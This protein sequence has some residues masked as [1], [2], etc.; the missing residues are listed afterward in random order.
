MDD[1]KNLNL[2]FSILEK[3]TDWGVQDL[4]VAAGGRNEP[5]VEAIH[6]VR[7]CFKVFSFFEERSAGF[8]ALGRMTRNGGRPVAV[9][10]TSGTAVGELLPAVME[11]FHSQLP[12]IVLSADRPS[13]HRG[14]GTP[15][16][17]DQ[18]GVFGNFVS[19]C[20][21]VT[22]LQDWQ[23]WK[24]TLHPIP[25]HINVCFEEPLIFPPACLTE[26]ALS[27]KNHLHFSEKNSSSW[28]PSKDF[29][30]LPHCQMPLF[31]PSWTD[32]SAY[33]RPLLI[34]SGLPTREEQ[35]R[36]KEWLLQAQV[37]AY[38]EA[39][40]GLREDPALQPYRIFCPEGFLARATQIGYPI[41]HVIRVGRVPTTRLWRDLEHS[42]LP[43]FSF[44]DLP[45]LGLARQNVFCFP[46]HTL[47]TRNIAFQSPP[48]LLWETEQQL[49]TQLASLLASEPLSEPSIVWQISQAIPEGSHIFLGTSLPIRS[50]DLASNPSRVSS[51]AAR[52]LNGIDGQV[53]YCLGSAHPKDTSHWGLLGDLGTL[54]DLS[55]AWAHPQLPPLSLNLVVINNYGGQIF[56]RLYPHR[57]PFYLGSH[58]LSF[59]SWATLWNFSYQCYPENTEL[60]IAPLGQPQ[61]IEARPNPQATERFWTQY[62]HMLQNLP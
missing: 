27:F 58:S 53:S 37:P 24:G 13:S 59:E 16:A 62:H 42:R 28:P 2:V 25:L 3:L 23:A 54:Y 41:D 7:S 44:S 31:S 36:V 49:G 18:K 39:W 20:V 22:C 21:D 19:A 4:L 43:V 1:Q 14:K 33:Q 30:L 50:W 26:A 47:Q 56:S 17:T 45:W 61:I 35:T 40:S 8:F 34:V 46:M 57:D 60:K 6:Q 11:G 9:F 52:G 29:E 51:W 15:Q 38:F 12:L 48:A 10:V 55:G 5:F 32:F